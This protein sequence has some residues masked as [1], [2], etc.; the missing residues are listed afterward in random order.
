VIVIAI[1]R[2]H[3]MTG[4]FT[5]NRVGGNFRKQL[6]NPFLTQAVSVTDRRSQQY[7]SILGKQGR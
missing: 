5:E 7:F 1:R 6:V 4:F 2:R 3:V